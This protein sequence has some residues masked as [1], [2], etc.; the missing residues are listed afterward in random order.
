MGEFTVKCMRLAAIEPDISCA[1]CWGGV[2]LVCEEVAGLLEAL[3]ETIAR[4][5]E[6]LVVLLQAP[7]ALHLV[8]RALAHLQGRGTHERL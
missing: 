3:G 4:G 5:F 7:L 1:M 2:H 6:P 8:P